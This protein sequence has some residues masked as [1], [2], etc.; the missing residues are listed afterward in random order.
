MRISAPATLSRRGASRR[1]L[2][3]HSSGPCAL[4]PLGR[5][6]TSSRRWTAGRLSMIPRPCGQLLR[7]SSSA[8]FRAATRATRTRPSVCRPVPTLMPC[9]STFLLGCQ[10]RREPCCPLPSPLRSWR[11]RPGALPTGAL[12]A[13]TGSLPSSTRR[14]GRSSVRSCSRFS[15]AL[16]L[17]AAKARCTRRLLR[18][19]SPSCSRREAFASSLGATAL[20]L[21]PAPTPRFLVG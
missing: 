1:D 6:F 11:K 5:L 19:S 9:C 21:C 16:W 7:P 13:L 4:A 15:Q 20:C 14:T 17:R 10:M 2:G 12:R 18:C 3:Q 8:F